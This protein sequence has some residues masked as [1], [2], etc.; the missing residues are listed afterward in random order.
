M[1]K[2][3][4]A[5]LVFLGILGCSTNGDI[6]LTGQLIYTGGGNK[7]KSLNLNRAE[8]DPVVLY[9]SRSD[10]AAIGHLAR[11]DNNSFLFDMCPVTEECVIKHY[12]LNSG[13]E[14]TIRRGRLPTYDPHKRMLFLYEGSD[15][16][17]G[18]LVTSTLENPQAIAR[19]AKEPKRKLLANGITQS[20]TTP[21]IQALPNQIVFTGE[22]TQLWMY[23]TSDSKLKPTGI[24]NCRAL[25]WGSKTKQLLCSDW[26]TWE[27]FLL[28]LQTGRKEEHPE[29]KGAYGFVYLPEYDSLVYGR[30]RGRVP[31][32]EGYDIF[33]YSF[34][35]EKEWKIRANDHIA[36][37]IY[38]KESNRQPGRP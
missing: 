5:I 32:G 21:V 36:N 37:G 38:N 7:V 2:T 14:R 3:A 26:D 25:V 17:R 1:N 12:D 6:E 22:D 29:L 18:W 27:I 30:T 9:E 33:C 34:K 19:V 24:K 11:I 13:R 15:G 4:V 8:S 20:V 35:D 10:V 16:E 23:N 28:D 31:A